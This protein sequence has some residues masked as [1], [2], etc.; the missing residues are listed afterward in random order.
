MK[1]TNDNIK[2]NKTKFVQNRARPL[3]DTFHI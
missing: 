2:I 1:E 3:N